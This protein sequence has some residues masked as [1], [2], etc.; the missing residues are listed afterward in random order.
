MKKIHYNICVRKNLNTNESLQQ[1]ISMHLKSV[2]SFSADL[3]AF[4]KEKKDS[5]PHFTGIG[6]DRKW[7]TKKTFFNCSKANQQARVIP[8]HQ[9]WYH[10]HPPNQNSPWLVWKTN[11]LSQSTFFCKYLLECSKETIHSAYLKQNKV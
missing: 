5:F 2:L 4:S 9:I 6:N 1:E 7:N 11:H 10:T 8:G 3:Q